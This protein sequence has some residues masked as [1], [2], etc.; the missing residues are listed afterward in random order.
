MAEVRLLIG[1][2]RSGKSKRL[3]SD[4]IECCSARNLVGALLVVPSSRYSKLAKERLRSQ[5]LFVDSNSEEGTGFSGG[6]LGLQIENFYTLCAQI[7]K[8][9]GITYRLIPESVRPA[10]VARAMGKLAEAGQLENLEPLADFKGTY[11]SVLELIDEFQRAGLSPQDVLSRVNESAADSSKHIELARIYQQ[12]W[13]ELDEIEFLDNRRL[14]FAAREYLSSCKSTD[15]L[16]SFVGVDGFDRFNRLQL[17]V[18]KELAGFCDKLTICFDYTESDENSDVKQEYIWKESSY[19]DLL[20]NFTRATVERLELLKNPPAKVKAVKAVD[21]FLEM[22]E[23]ARSIKCGVVEKSVSPEDVLVVVPSMRKYRTAIESAFDS[24]EVP[25]F[26]DDAIPLSTVPVIQY[27]RK[28]LNLFKEDFQRAGVVSVISDHYFKNTN[29]SQLFKF[30]SIIDEISMETLLVS[31]KKSWLALDL[32]K[33][34]IDELGSFLSS[35]T[36]PQEKGALTDFVSWVEDLVDT[37]LFLEDDDDHSDPMQAWVAGRAIAEFRSCL[38]GLVQEDLVLNADKPEDMIDYFSFL[39]HL[40]HA[41]ESANFRSVSTYETPINICS[42]DLAPNRMFSRVYIAGLAEGE[43]PRRAKAKGFVSFDELSQWRSYGVSIENPRLHPAF[44]YGLFQSLVKRAGDTVFLTH[45]MWDMAGDEILPS[46]FITGGDLTEAVFECAPY[47]MSVEKPYSYKDFV[48]GSLATGFD[49]NQLAMLLNPNVDAITSALEDQSSMLMAR[50][51]SLMDSNYNG[52][53]EEQ[54]SLKTLNVDTPEMWSASRLNEYG[55]C[56]FR[57]WVSNVLKIEVHEEPTP[58]IDVRVLGKMYHKALEN[59]YQKVIDLKI[60]RLSDKL[61]Q[62]EDLF[63]AAVED[64]VNQLEK[65]TGAPENEF[66]SFHRKEIEFRL[67]RFFE[68][69]LERESKAKEFFRPYKVEASFG[70]DDPESMPALVLKD[71]SRKVEL[72]GIIDRIDISSDSS[73]HPKYRIV[74]YK[75]GSRQITKKEAVLGRDMQMPLYM[76]ALEQ[77][78]NPGTE[79]RIGSYLSVSSG[80]SI[81]LIK[82]KTKEEKEELFEKVKAHVHTY[83][84]SIENG[85]FSVKPNGNTVCKGCSHNLICR[86]NELKKG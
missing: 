46:F 33:S 62:V 21:R 69:E 40:E 75:A 84:E 48:S 6:L 76:M 22:E 20:N 16:F 47:T 45:P 9:A 50:I 18:L 53:L 15:K 38:G 81:G 74:D 35:C 83:V 79:S 64:A 80:E 32:D 19:N 72:R 24:A 41:L 43:F 8:K 66:W 68:K 82:Y 27:L 55:K 85:D 59:F 3:Y 86:I 10:I 57:F 63:R 23:I 54:V 7:L 44:E 60:E 49:T 65:D 5:L 2:Y 13:Q 42:V 73:M 71:G 37:L 31:G 58:D 51:N 4:L 29:Y 11:G 25:Y 34:I 70:M 52:C 36:P 61:S 26:V 56:P 67:S 39:N 28:L 17:D 1:P 77:A 14:A 30:K 78:G 12:Y